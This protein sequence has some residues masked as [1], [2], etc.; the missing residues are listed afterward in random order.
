MFRK[1]DKAPAVD[2]INTVKE[3]GLR[4]IAFIMD[5]NG[6]WAKRR[7]LP[8][9]AGHVAGAKTF[10]KVIKYC[11]DIGIDTITVYAFSTE[12]WKRPQRE[13]EA[14]MKLLDEYI[15]IAEDEDEENRV[16]YIFLG[17]KDALGEELKNKCLELEELTKNYKR[18]LNAALNY[19]GRAE[20]VH[21]VNEAIKAGA[22]HITEEDIERNLYTAG[23]PD[24]DLIVRTAG[25]IRLSNFLM[26]Q[27]AYSEFYFTDVL[28]PDMSS[29]EVDKAI[30]EFSKRKRNF[31]GVKNA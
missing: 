4:H 26:W 15:R 20:I 21:A 2:I 18:T 14:L 10:K 6:R 17:D 30:I 22:D 19:G 9:E 31:G 23:S 8:R 5:G 27:S 11:S 7:S 16:R 28:W 13:V 29:D 24:P 12:N 3:S 1:K 25:E